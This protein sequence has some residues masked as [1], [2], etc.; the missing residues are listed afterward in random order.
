MLFVN[1]IIFFILPLVWQFN[2]LEAWVKEIDT[3]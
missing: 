3:S 2:H 1:E